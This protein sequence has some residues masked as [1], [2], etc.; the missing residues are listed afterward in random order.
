MK[1]GIMTITNDKPNYG[2]RLQNYA[3]Q[4]VLESIGCEVETINNINKRVITKPYKAFVK[5]IISSIHYNISGFEKDKLNT[6]LREKRFND[7]N[8]K[9]IKKSKYFVTE[10]NIP[11][12]LA[13][14]YDYFVCGSDQ[15]WNPCF[16]RSSKLDFLTFA[17]KGQ[18]ISYSASFGI[19]EIPEERKAEYKEWIN[20]LDYIS[21]REEAGADIVKNLTGR[22]ATVLVDPTLMLT[23]EEWRSIAKKPKLNLEQKYL[24]TYFLGPISDESKKK[25]ENFAKKR[26]LKVINLLD[27]KDK[28][29]Y[30]VDP[31]EFI[32]LID[33]CELM[34]TDSFH[35]C[36][37]S[38]ILNTPFVVFERKSKGKSMNSR[39]D[40]LLK[41]FS[42]QDR[43]A[44]NVTFNS[45]LFEMNFNNVEPI[46][47]REKKRAKE[48]LK[49]AIK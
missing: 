29:I 15:I 17:K 49:N 19:S 48:F 5:N 21:V 4:R 24:L 30:S 6:F 2:N 7:F 33:N 16:L 32:Y 27:K 39:I 45:N 22:D 9:Y 42:M 26:N 41:L 47:E 8:K 1:V 18:R 20:G 38:I 34:C 13:D 10:T 28:F 23:N 43:L 40:T 46:L 35:G 11:K 3:V 37:F 44:D 31:S 25:I 14:S 36:V 12:D